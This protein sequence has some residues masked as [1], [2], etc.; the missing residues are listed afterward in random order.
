MIKGQTMIT[1]NYIT[2]DMGVGYKE[3]ECLLEAEMFEQQ[4]LDLGYTTSLDNGMHISSREKSI[5]E[6]VSSIKEVALALL[7][8]EH[9]SI[10]LANILNDRCV[11]IEIA[12]CC[13]D[14]TLE[15]CEDSIDLS[16][17]QTIIDFK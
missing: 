4:M 9:T 17:L 6:N 12:L 5:L 11:D 8:E 14:T 1:V 10:Y 13:P 7:Q 15:L 16:Q 3:F 2:P